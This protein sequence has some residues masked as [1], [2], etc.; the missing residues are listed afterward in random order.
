MSCPDEAKNLKVDLEPGSVDV[1]H[2]IPAGLLFGVRFIEKP[3]WV[4]GRES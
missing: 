3:S 4:L 1:G 2:P